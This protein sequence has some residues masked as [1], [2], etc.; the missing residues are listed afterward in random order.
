MYQNILIKRSR[1]KGRFVIQVGEQM[2]ELNMIKK[3]ILHLYKTNPNIHM[4]VSISRPKISLKNAKA[5]ITGI[6]PHIFQI[7]ENSSGVPKNHTI[8]YVDILTKNI[9]ILELQRR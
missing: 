6:Y 8:Q 1:P 7:T 5:T 9:A 2:T 3:D 4:D